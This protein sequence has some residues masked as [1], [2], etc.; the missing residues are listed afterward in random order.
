MEVKY[1]IHN[2]FQHCS[3]SLDNKTYSYNSLMVM[4]RE[5]KKKYLKNYQLTKKKRNLD[6]NDFKFKY[7]HREFEKSNLSENEIKNYFF[8]K[9][10][11]KAKSWLS[12]NRRKRRQGKLTQNQIESLNEFGMMWNP[13][14]DIWEKNF[15]NY[16]SG[17]TIDI[18]KSMR[19][20]SW[21]IGAAR[22]RKL[23]ELEEWE[24]NQ[25][26]LFEN[27]TLSKEN[28]LRLKA[29]NFPFKSSYE[30][31]AIPLSSL[32]ALI[33]R[34]RELNQFEAFFGRTIEFLEDLV[35]PIILDEK[36]EKES[37]QIRK[38]WEKQEKIKKDA[39]LKILENKS[40]AYFLKYIDNI[41]KHKPL[42]WN[43]KN[44]VDLS[45]KK[46]FSD[47]KKKLEQYEKLKQIIENTF[48]FPRTKL[49]NLVYESVYLNYEFNDEIKKYAANKM[50]I[51]LDDYLLKSGIINYKKRFKPITY[52]MDI[53]KK[54]NNMEGLLMLKKLIDNHEILNILYKQ[55]LNKNL[56]RLKLK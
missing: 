4:F 37:S 34:I 18:L 41:C 10:E 16:K 12:S 27:G 28:L 48:L 31:S 13:N 14:T 45:G 7:G 52:L 42:S 15:I 36:E 30:Q 46:I 43:Q 29:I 50:I 47:V 38:K 33:S 17:F 23:I 5:T 9:H 40:N 11:N 24:K 51:L 21:S 32:I 39:A 53:Y 56:K 44:I 22:L 55:R 8:S 49:N 25:K 19:S 3:A 54:E 6:I 1:R 2:E 20:K 26:I 35:Q